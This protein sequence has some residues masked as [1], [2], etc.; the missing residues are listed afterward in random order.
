M[1]SLGRSLAALNFLATG[2]VCEG[3][4]VHDRQQPHALFMEFAVD[5]E[6][7]LRGEWPWHVL[8]A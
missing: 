3:D 5:Y 6:R 8:R 7:T 2:E 4:T 1:R